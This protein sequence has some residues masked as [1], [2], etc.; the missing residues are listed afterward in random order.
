MTEPDVHVE[1]LGW[2]PQ[3][4]VV[5][6]APWGGIPVTLFRDGLPVTPA[7]EPLIPTK[8]KKTEKILRPHLDALMEALLL[9]DEAGL[10]EPSCRDHPHVITC[11]WCDAGGALQEAISADY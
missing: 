4:S 5:R 10:L 6:S 11:K 7:R 9:A 2:V 3:T 1:G 8:W